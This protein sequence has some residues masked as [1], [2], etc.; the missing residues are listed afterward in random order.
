MMGTWSVETGA[1]RRVRWRR[2]SFAQVEQAPIK[3][4]VE[5]YVEMAWLYKEQ[6]LL[7][8]TTAI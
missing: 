4:H 5:T 7:T 2:G 3:T 1:H 6:A 8:V